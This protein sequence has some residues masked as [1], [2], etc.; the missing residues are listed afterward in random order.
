MKKKASSTKT[1]CF[2]HLRLDPKLK[3]VLSVEAEAEG[4]TLSNY[5]FELINQARKAR[6]DNYLR[7]LETNQP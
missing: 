1:N 5:V 6:K 4:R 3:A 2:M 7:T